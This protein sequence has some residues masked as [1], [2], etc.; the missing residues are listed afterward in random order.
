MS[1]CEEW[2]CCPDHII[3]VPVF[4]SYV[5][6]GLSFACAVVGR[7]DASSHASAVA[8]LAVLAETPLGTEM[9]Q[10][11]IA[12][13]ASAENATAQLLSSIS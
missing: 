2:P 3:L 13:G 4:G 7:S 9:M 11:K 6:P 12:G 5:D 10:P 1:V 8:R